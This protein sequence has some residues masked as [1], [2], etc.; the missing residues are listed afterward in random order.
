MFGLLILVAAASYFFLYNFDEK[1]SRTYEVVFYGWQN[2]VI[3]RALSLFSSNSRI[4]KGFLL[5]EAKRNILK[6]P[7][8]VWRG[9]QL[10]VVEVG[11]SQTP[12]IYQGVSYDSVNLRAVPKA[13]AGEDGLLTIQVRGKEMTLQVNNSTLIYEISFDKPKTLVGRGKSQGA[14]LLNGESLALFVVEEGNFPVILDVL[15]LII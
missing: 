14:R 11:S 9:E 8:N 13:W 10:G 7:T 1:V 2:R 12:E 4:Y 5:Y 6:R 15:I 3:A